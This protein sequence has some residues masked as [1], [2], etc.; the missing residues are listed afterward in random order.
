MATEQRVQS[1]EWWPTQSLP[2]REEYVGPAVCAQCH[3][4][5]AAIQT[6][7]PMAK[8]C[9]RAAESPILKAHPRMAF[10]LG[11]YA[12]KIVRTGSG[13]T[14]SV[15]DGSRDVTLPLGWVFGDGEVG[16]T[17][18][19]QRQGVSYE[20]QVSYFSA[21]QALDV[22]PGHSHSVPQDL[23]GAIGRPLDAEETHL[24]FGCHN[25]A[26]SA[27]GQFDP[28]HLIPGVTCEACH[29]PGAKHVA[30]MK[31]GRKAEG[32][33]LV[34]NPAKLNAVDSVDFCGACHRT[35]ADVAEAGTVG[36][37]TVR[38][39]PY[40]LESSRCWGKGDSRITCLAC[41]DPHLP[42]VRDPASYDSRCLRCHL[43]TKGSK[44]SP[45]HP[46]AACLVATKNCVTCHMPKY[47]A[48]DT[49]TLFT[50]HRIRIVTSDKHYPD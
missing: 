19:L 23:D 42:L 13:S 45:D 28:D 10:R 9:I 21:L 35:W 49:H 41:H 14:F 36:V 44:G 30:A 47:E 3:A 4:S 6:T 25:T 12:Y 34:K 1:A 26:S 46:G 37:A 27:A 22:T 11:Q 18:V 33:A 32:L 15:S 17:Y 31:A 38:F 39:Q 16:E 5:E 29:G 40:R 8:A 24:C 48:P 2:R 50:D 43:T 20:S 7:T